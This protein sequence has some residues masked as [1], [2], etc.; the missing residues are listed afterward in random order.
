MEN[1]QKAGVKLDF[2][3]VER[4]K[5]IAVDVKGTSKKSDNDKW[6]IKKAMFRYFYPDTELREVRK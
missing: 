6:P 4:G 2:S 1:G 5:L 3:F